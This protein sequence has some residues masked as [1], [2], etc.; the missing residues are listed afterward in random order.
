MNILFA[1]A[2]GL[3]GRLAL[4]LLLRRLPAQ[5]RVVTVGRRAPVL[6]DPR[7]L[8]IVGALDDADLHARLDAA[9]VA[10][11]PSVFVCALGTTL[12][13][14]GSGRAFA[15]LD[16]DAVVGLAERA[17][18]H[19]ARQAVVVSSVGADAD[20]PSL[21]LR[22]KGEMQAAV[23]ALGFARTDFLQPGLLLGDRPD[24]QRHGERIAQRLAP[25]YN[26]FLVGRW[27]RYRA[28]PAATVASALVAL[29]DAPGGGV[30]LH[31]NDALIEWAG[32]DGDG[33]SL[34]EA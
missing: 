12:K 18:A 8:P 9:M 14:A 6:S 27:H 24:A 34:G 1:G 11:P 16:R 4:P 17:R 2:T 13:Q 20:S 26:P 29:L 15:A 7:V 10:H 30:T 25:F 32:S 31:R 21:Y 33:P 3:V 23:T 5:A 22:V 28:I 19:G